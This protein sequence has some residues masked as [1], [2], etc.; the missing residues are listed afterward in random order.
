MAKCLGPNHSRG[1]EL[2][3]MK[4]FLLSVITVA[5]A[6]AV[7]AG[8]V[9]DIKAGT[10]LEMR[11]VVGGTFSAS[12]LGVTTTGPLLPSA[13]VEIVKAAAGLTAEIPTATVFPTLGITTTLSCVGNPSP[14]TNG[15]EFTVSDTA[16]IGQTITI[17][18]DGQKI[19][20]V[21]KEVT[22]TIFMVAHPLGQP[23]KDA[24]ADI[25]RGTSLVMDAEHTS[26]VTISGMS[27]VGTVTLT[28]EPQLGGIGGEAVTQFVTGMSTDATTTNLIVS[29]T[30]HVGH[31]S[32]LAA[33]PAGG[34]KVTLTGNLFGFAGG[35]STTTVTVPEGAASAEFTF[36]VAT[37]Y[38]S[39]LDGSITATV[40]DFSYT[41]PIVA[42]SLL[43]TLTVTT[44][45]IVSGSPVEFHLKLNVAAPVAITVNLHSSDPDL[46]LPASV[47]IAAGQS[48]ITFDAQ[49]SALL[50]AVQL[51]V[52]ITAQYAGSISGT[53]ISTF[54]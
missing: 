32:L 38:S 22:G 3:N 49:T 20:V 48:S 2:S 1:V 17:A 12:A 37:I 52:Y 30:T 9:D 15:I 19:P 45:K 13:P 41:K 50:P 47:V 42:M 23:V 28:L 10:G 8:P 35:A 44:P 34:T 43:G 16:E 33:A 51:P 24:F 27:A 7:F 4:K 14:T 46:T 39:F 40:G 53:T 36:K 6:A 26:S 25:N 31:I 21:V 18:A 54:S 29:G 5:A 11:S